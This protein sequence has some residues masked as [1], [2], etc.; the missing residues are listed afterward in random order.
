MI[1]SFCRPPEML[2][3]MLFI[4]I[5]LCHNT[6]QI[7]KKSTLQKKI[8][9]FLILYFILIGCFMV[10]TAISD[11]STTLLRDGIDSFHEAY[12]GWDEKGFQLSLSFFK[13]ASQT[14]SKDGLAEYWSG[15]IYF[16]LSL[17]NLFSTEKAP[18]KVR[19]I[20][21]AEKGIKI[22]TKS[23]DLSPGFSESYALRGVLRGIL[24]K[25]KPFSAFTQGRKVGKD[26]EKALTLDADNPRVH[27]L[28]GVSF[29]FAPEILG[30]SDKALGHL[31]EAERLFE[32]ERQN[33]KNNL[34]PS[35]GQSTCLAF[36]GDI[37]LSQ[38]QDEK[39]LTYYE[40]ALKV[41]PNDPLAIRG[42]KRTDG[43]KY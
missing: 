6:R 30:G 34:L 42:I 20:E 26:R 2:K 25:M 29:W 22:L 43:M 3:K 16:F 24:I 36:I 23:I 1:Q 4:G 21:N 10:Q 37:Y 7:I 31:L 17:R 38:K 15:T 32:K 13:K 18:D 8:S 39:A 11:D 40:K 9:I 19:G 12:D 41:N 14:G 33:L 28:T 5:S 27:Y 35:W